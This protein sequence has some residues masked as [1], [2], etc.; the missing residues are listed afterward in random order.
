VAST[1]QVRNSDALLLNHHYVMEVR[2]F[3][4]PR[5]PGV[6]LR[7]RRESQ[8]PLLPQ[9]A[10]HCPVLEAGSGV[11]FLVH[12][13]LHAHEAFQIGYEGEGRYR[14]V[15]HGNPSGRKWEAMFSVSFQLPI[16]AVGMC[17]EEVT[18]H[19]AMPAGSREHALLLTRTFVVP[20]D[21][22]TPAGAV[23]L[24]GAWNFQTPQGWDTVYTP[25][26]NMI[27]RP[28]APMLVVRVETDWHVHESEFRYVL[29]PGEAISAEST[30]PIGQV[31]FVPRE[32]VIMRDCTG[33][34]LATIRQSMEAFD[35]EKAAVKLTAP[36]GLR[37]SPH[38]LRSSRAQKS[39]PAVRQ[40]GRNDLCPCGGGKKYKKCHGAAT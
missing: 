18:F 13:P 36:Y 28:V 3:P 37:Y 35:R 33:D 32:D 27:E 6:G 1:S 5:R 10:R 21:L 12:P 8:R 17:K 30:L 22:G 2:L 25:I 15:Y 16:G 29:Q 26:F 38:Y 24:R 20:E 4:N 9:H 11:G 40:V 39:E 19:A 34:E 7:P 23:T 31:L 14:F